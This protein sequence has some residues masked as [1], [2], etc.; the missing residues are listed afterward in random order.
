MNDMEIPARYF[1]GVRPVAQDVRLRRVS[2]GL[3]IVMADGRSPVLWPYTEARIDTD[4]PEVRLHRV[5]RGMDTGERIVAASNDF[6]GL[7]GAVLTQFGKGRAGEASGGRI[8][9]W[10]IAAIASLIFLYFI[11]LP[12]FARLAAPFVPWSWEA[13][14]GR[15]IEPQVLEL[16]GKGKAPA[17]CG[18]ADS[19]GKAALDA[20]VARLTVETKLPAPLR[21]DILDTPMSN[22]FALPGA[23]IF[24]FRP[25]LEKAETPDEVAGVL[26]HEIGHV[27]HRDSMRA[28]IHDGVLSLLVGAILGD[29]TG[30]ST[31]AILSKMMLGSAYSR[32]NEIEADEVSVRLMRQ[33]GADPR[34]INAFF[35]RISL[36][37]KGPSSF[38][39]A[40]SSHPVTSERI[41]TVEALSADA[42]KGGKP[43]LDAKEWAALKGICA[44]GKA[45]E[46]R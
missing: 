7:F 35:R 19:R 3:E 44:E 39:D 4:T 37:G 21:V 16:F 25:I 2:G 31:V 32:E 33:A 30:G 40:F 6:H 34:A 11:G 18:T 26:A 24:L 12:A 28:L 5:A 42:P 43:I 15:S 22:A 27:L 8:A 45:A 38:L 17:I 14:L 41:A 23:R 36:P 46:L 29:V 20:M 13:S 1:D 10:C 9:L